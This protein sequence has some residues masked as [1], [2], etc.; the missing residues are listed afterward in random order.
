VLEQAGEGAGAEHDGP[1]LV[2]GADAVKQG[3]GQGRDVFAAHAQRGNGEADGGEPEGQVGHEK[4]LTGHLAERGLRGGQHHGAA[5]GT[6]LERLEDAEEQ[7]LA[8][9]GKQVNAVK[10]GE[11]G[12]GGGIGVGYQPFTGIAALEAGRGER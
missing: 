3:L 8:G 7:T 6:V 1:L 4:A 5:R 2:A 11:A 9:G 10:V 12:K